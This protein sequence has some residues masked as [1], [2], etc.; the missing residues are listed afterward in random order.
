MK[1]KSLFSA[2]LWFYLLP[3]ILAQPSIARMVGTAQA[4]QFNE[5]ELIQNG[6]TSDYYMAGSTNGIA[7]FTRLDQNGDVV[8]ARQLNDNPQAQS[9]FFDFVQDP[10]SGDFLVVGRIITPNPGGGGPIWRSIICRID[11]NGNLVYCLRYR[12]VGRNSF[13]KIV[14]N[15]VANPG[16]GYIFYVVG[17][18]SNATAGGNN[19]EVF[20]MNIAANLA[21]GVLDI[22]WA[23]VYDLTQFSDDQMVRTAIPM[24]NGGIMIS[25]DCTNP[26]PTACSALIF[27]NGATPTDAF[28]SSI[29]FRHNAQFN[30]R[31]AVF[32]PASGLG[33][34]GLYVTGSTNNGDAFI[35]LLNPNNLS[36]AWTNS[37]PAGPTGFDDGWGVEID[38]ANNIFLVGEQAVNN[39][40]VI[41]QLQD[42]G[43]GFQVIGQGTFYNSGTQANAFDDFKI[44]GNQ[45]IYLD[46]RINTGIFGVSNND[47]LLVSLPLP[48]NSCIS[49]NTNIQRQ[50][51][52]FTTFT[53]AMNVA[54][55]QIPPQEPTICTVNPLTIQSQNLCCVNLSVYQD[56]TTVFPGVTI[57]GDTQLEGKYYFPP[58]TLLTVT[59]NTV[60][61]ITNVDIVFDECSG[62]DFINGA[63][64]R[65]NNSVFR[66]CEDDMLW[67]GLRFDNS[68]GNKINECT[69]KNA[70]NALYFEGLNGNNADGVISNNLFYNNQRSL[71]TD[72]V[73]FNF[74]IS[75]NRFL[76]DQ[77]LPTQ[78]CNDPTGVQLAGIWSDQTIFRE[79][80]SHN[81]FLLGDRID[82]VGFYY[83]VFGNAIAANISENIFT[84]MDRSIDIKNAS[85]QVDIMQNEVDKNNRDNFVF[86]PFDI[87]IYIENGKYGT[88]IIG[89]ELLKNNLPNPAPLLFIG[90]LTQDVSLL[91]LEE[92]TIRGFSNGI[93]LHRTNF[94]NVLENNISDA[95]ISGISVTESF[96]NAIACNE[97]DL[98]FANPTLTNAGRGI[99]LSDVNRSSVYSNCVFD[100]Q[101]SLYLSHSVPNTQIPTIANNYLYNYSSTGIYS[102]NYAGSIGTSAQPGLNTLWSNNNAAVDIQSVGTTLNAADNFGM[103]NISGVAITSNNPYH[104]T[105]SCAN[106]IFNMPSQGN[107]N[108]AY[109]CNRRVASALPIRID[110]SGYSLRENF[111]DELQS[112]KGEERFEVALTIQNVLAN[113]SWE[114]VAGFRT[115]LDRQSLLGEQDDQR[116][117]Y[118]LKRLRGDKQAA[119]G[120]LEKISPASKQVREWKAIE[121][122]LFN[123]HTKKEGLQGVTLKSLNYLESIAA[124]DGKNASRARSILNFWDSESYPIDLEELLSEYLNN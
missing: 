86:L 14:V 64:V 84:D 107:H 29:G 119:R 123:L 20:V 114:K 40:F 48:L 7:T 69:F 65:A 101:H 87:Q 94:S 103:F 9:Q 60:L 4:D 73:V 49:V 54:Q 18:Q 109:D 19:D 35:S 45:F 36:V 67:S 17:S 97:I 71:R 57:N 108:L 85:G 79:N 113:A 62:I 34:A 43:N 27:Q 100:C 89:N 92:N 91:Q 8:W 75:G 32:S 98:D 47:A 2:I 80:I 44:I 61:D 78:N 68:V 50:N 21:G 33:G 37:L 16:T 41:T 22:L 10:V 105:A 66:T 70:E 52:G 115:E 39:R 63:Q 26:G 121:M 110:S 15:P 42:V 12:L 30:I 95:I 59:G 117:D 99:L 112:Y 6:T 118:Y 55:L 24:P 13:T 28:G 82:F 76:V 93:W 25:G 5:V 56:I 83:G 116:L 31:D 23:N 3:T 74:A 124:G 58:N 88:Q 53:A 111:V 51:D 1:K 90:I 104:S 77:N 106:Q 122:A 72:N 46:E 11:Q 81:N 96:G 120:I 38:A 102:E